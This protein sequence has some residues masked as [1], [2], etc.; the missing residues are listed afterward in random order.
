MPLDDKGSADGGGDGK[1]R[2]MVIASSTVDLVDLLEVEDV[3]VFLSMTFHFA[4]SSWARFVL[5]PGHLRTFRR[6]VTCDQSPLVPQSPLVMVLFVLTN[7][8]DAVS[9]RQIPSNLLKRRCVTVTK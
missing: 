9:S 2:N 5:L 3:L 7:R 8:R 1:P 6:L 4:E